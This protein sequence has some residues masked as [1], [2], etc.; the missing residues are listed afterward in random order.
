[1]RDE[2]PKQSETVVR[3]F[4]GAWTRRD[5]DG[6]C[7]M[8]SPDCIWK[9]PT[10]PPYVGPEAIREVITGAIQRADAIEMD[11][12]ALSTTADGNA[13]LCERLD[14]MIYGEQRVPIPVM[15]IF[16]VRDGLITAWRDYF[17]QGSY[18]KNLE[19]IGQT[20]GIQELDQ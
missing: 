3:S 6:I 12:L 4:A 8:L 19:A 14:A 7:S 16:E 20:P 9:N 10:S 11:F 5:V 18:R 13:V 17:D 15:G 2:T 1:M